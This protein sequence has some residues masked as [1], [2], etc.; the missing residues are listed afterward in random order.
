MLLARTIREVP[1]GK[2]DRRTLCCNLS[3]PYDDLL[4]ESEGACAMAPSSAEAPANGSA[5]IGG[6]GS[7]RSV[8]EQRVLVGRT[9]AR[10]RGLWVIG[11][12]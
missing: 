4:G 5:V 7:G 2:T 6:W 3:S 8:C 9:L 11:E 12:R 10:P 1:L